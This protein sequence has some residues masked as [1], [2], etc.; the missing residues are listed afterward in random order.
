M[1][2]EGITE[3]GDV[4]ERFPHADRLEH[5]RRREWDRVGLTPPGSQHRTLFQLTLE[6]QNHCR[7]AARTIDRSVRSHRNGLFDGRAGLCRCISLPHALVR[8]GTRAVRRRST[9]DSPFT[10]I[11]LVQTTASD[12]PPEPFE[13]ATAA[14]ANGATTNRARGP[15]HGLSQMVREQDLHLCTRY[16]LRGAFDYCERAVA[17]DIR[18]WR[19]G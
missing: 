7:H 15:C 2:G 5:P 8:A 10:P 13:T 4:A 19:M 14:A 18:P 9:P 16:A 12:P 17:P 11:A 3:A 1:K 6:R